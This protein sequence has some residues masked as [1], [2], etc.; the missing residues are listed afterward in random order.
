[1]H[2]QRMTAIEDLT[3][4]LEFLNAQG[5][6]STVRFRPEI[7][8]LSNDECVLTTAHQLLEED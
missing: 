2:M 7:H 1:M 5:Q 4:M 6:Q 3:M 8:Q